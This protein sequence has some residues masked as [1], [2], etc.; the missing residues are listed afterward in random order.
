MTDE[1]KRS[2]D[3]DESSMK[4]AMDDFMKAMG[5]D[6]EMHKAKVLSQWEE[7]MGEAVAKRTDKKYIRDKVLHLEM[8]SSVMRDELMQKRSEIIK[9][10]NELAGYEMIE[11]IFLA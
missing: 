5:V 3:K 2:G 6:K 8:S 1:L 4:D 10:F 11:E 7:L 9:K